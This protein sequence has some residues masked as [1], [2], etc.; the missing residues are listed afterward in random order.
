MIVGQYNWRK[1]KGLPVGLLQV[2]SGPERLHKSDSSWGADLETVAVVG[3]AAELVVGCEFVIDIV[4]VDAPVIVV[5]V[6]GDVGVDD[7][8]DVVVVADY[9]AAVVAGVD[10]VDESA[11]GSAVVGA[12]A[13]GSKESGST[14]QLVGAKFELE[15]FDESLHSADRN[16]SGTYIGVA[17]WRRWS[18][19]LRRRQWPAAGCGAESVEAGEAPVGR[20]A[21]QVMPRV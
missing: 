9:A 2:C 13:V 8:D 20:P 7:Y 6:A 1:H 11:V 12:I 14:E 4:V 3:A 19:R 18:R 15:M 21:G 10:C 5:V 17:Q 16:N